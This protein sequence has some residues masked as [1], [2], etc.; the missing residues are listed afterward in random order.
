MHDFVRE[1]VCV[2][3]RGGCT[4]LMATRV[5]CT[6]RLATEQW[7]RRYKRSRG[8]L[9]RSG[10]RC[11]LQSPRS[12]EVEAAEVAALAQLPRANA[13]NR[14]VPLGQVTPVHCTSPFRFAPA[15]PIVHLCHVACSGAGQ[16]CRPGAV[17]LAHRPAHHSS[18]CAKEGADS[19]QCLG[20]GVVRASDAEPA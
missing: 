12:S 18:T 5:A 15:L 2:F 6:S 16:G 8:T 7:T 13:R 10:A 19:Y 14:C 17:A 20:P 1:W 3:G 9:R 4:S 11:P